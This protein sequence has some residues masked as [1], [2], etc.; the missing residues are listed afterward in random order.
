VGH[1]TGQSKVHQH[2]RH[3][4]STVALLAGVLFGIGMLR[5]RFSKS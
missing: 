5:R 4:G 2:R 3:S 1:L